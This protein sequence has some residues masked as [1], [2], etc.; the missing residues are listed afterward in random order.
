MFYNAK[1]PRICY[2]LF[3]MIF[4]WKIDFVIIHI[5]HIYIQNCNNTYILYIILN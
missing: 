5:I 1:Y 3:E 2:N 4:Y